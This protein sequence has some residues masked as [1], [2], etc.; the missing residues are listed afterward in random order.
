[1]S[2]QVPRIY[3]D[4]DLLDS[5]TWGFYL[6]GQNYYLEDEPIMVLPG[7]IIIMF[8]PSSHLTEKEQVPEV[9]IFDSHAT[10]ELQ[11]GIRVKRF[12]ENAAYVFYEGDYEPIPKETL[13]RSPLT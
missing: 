4:E 7:K 13:P 5:M 3:L 6:P 8:D 9:A 2:D 11:K 10:K 1:M 12:A